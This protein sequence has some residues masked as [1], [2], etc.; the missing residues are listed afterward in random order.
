MSL[1]NTTNQLFLNIY[2]GQYNI[3]VFIDLCKAFDT[4]NQSILLCKLWHYGIRAKAQ[5]EDSGSN[6][7]SLTDTSTLQYLVMTLILPACKWHTS[8]F[9]LGSCIILGLC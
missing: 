6:L 5:V 2:R 9:Q 3:A 8:G 4:V 1:L 7:T